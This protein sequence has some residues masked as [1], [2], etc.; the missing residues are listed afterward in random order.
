MK[1]A[2]SILIA[3]LFCA[4][5]VSAHSQQSSVLATIADGKDWT[6]LQSDGQTGKIRLSS[7]G[8]GSM[9]IGERTLSP[10]WRVGQN[11]ELC[12]KLALIIPERCVSLVRDGESVLG[13]SGGAHQF[14]LSRK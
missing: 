11:G 4:P 14:R 9:Q 13:I 8:T 7:N 10:K 1:I 2:K 12:L 3:F 5:T 6:I